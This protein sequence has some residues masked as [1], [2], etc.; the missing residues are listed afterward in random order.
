MAPF[1]NIKAIERWYLQMN[2]PFWSL[3]TTS[4]GKRERVEFFEPENV[5]DGWPRLEMAILDRVKGVAR[6]SIYL[7]N[8]KGNTNGVW[9]E[10]ELYESAPAAIPGIGSM[11]ATVGITEAEFEKRLA[12]ER[13]RWELKRDIADL[14]ANKESSIGAF[15]RLFNSIAQNP[16]SIAPILDRIAMVVAAVRGGVQPGA[17]PAPV[18]GTPQATECAYGA[19]K[20]VNPDESGDDDEIFK[21]YTDEEV[22]VINHAVDTIKSETGHNPAHVMAKLAAALKKNPSLINLLDQV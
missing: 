19:E 17:I 15:D 4:N 2:M 18:N 5:N 9:Q 6:M 11:P 10:I 20:P 13:E 8:G 22:A 12:S 21:G 14:K 1:T 16:A 7:S 3:H